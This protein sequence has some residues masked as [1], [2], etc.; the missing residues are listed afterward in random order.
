MYGR[1][2]DIGS[3]FYCDPPDSELEELAAVRLLTFGVS[4][5][6]D[7]ITIREKVQLAGVE[8]VE[9]S[10]L[11]EANQAASEAEATLAA[12]PVI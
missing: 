1:L 6:V 12:T 7:E 4:T 8:N 3:L 2:A 10:P 5:I 11:K 9:L